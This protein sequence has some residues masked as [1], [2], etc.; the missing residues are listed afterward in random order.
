MGI[1]HDYGTANS[2]FTTTD[3]KLNDVN[4]S[5]DPA[6]YESQLVGSNATLTASYVFSSE[7]KFNPAATWNSTWNPAIWD[8]L[9]ENILPTLKHCGYSD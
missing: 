5:S 3:S 1:D 2:C 7:Q 9:E 4:V 6:E 8:N